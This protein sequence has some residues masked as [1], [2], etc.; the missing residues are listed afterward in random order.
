MVVD[1]VV[2]V[3]RD[4]PELAGD[5]RLGAGT[6]PDTGGPELGEVAAQQ[7][8]I[9]RDRRCDDGLGHDALAGA[10]R[11]AAVVVVLDADRA[12]LIGVVTAIGTI[13][14]VVVD[15]GLHPIVLVITVLV[16]T[17]LGAVVGFAT[18]SRAVNFG[19]GV[20]PA[21]QAANQSGITG[22]EIAMALVAM[23]VWP[24]IAM[25]LGV[26]VATWLAR[27]LTEWAEAAGYGD[28]VPVVGAVA[29]AALLALLGVRVLRS[30]DKPPTIAALTKRI[31]RGDGPESWF[32][33]QRA[34]LYL[35]QGDDELAI[36]DYT[37]AIELDPNGVHAFSGRG[38]VHAN[39][40][41]LTL[42]IAEYTRTIDL[43]APDCAREVGAIEHFMESSRAGIIDRHLRPYVW[44]A[45]ARAASGD[46]EGAQADLDH[47]LQLAGDHPSVKQVA[48]FVTEV[49]AVR[50][51]VGLGPEG[52][53]APT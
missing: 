18:G 3:D 4:R 6:E 1:E 31:E 27:T 20:V 16:G 26:V 49:E 36:A 28:T 2:A 29:V 44:R 39:R 11:A 35:K 19:G 9:E 24:V 13:V 25:G 5:G 10:C 33:E 7:Q 23:V 45:E 51:S 42:A 21:R 14:L 40:G 53:E 46:L 32:L 17:I 48:A 43:D 50:R 12:V 38:R 34:R 22:R 37:R 30:A 52:A 47:V 15:T 8:G 41:D